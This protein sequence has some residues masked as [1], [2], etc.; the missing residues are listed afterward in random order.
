VIELVAR[1]PAERIVF[2][3]DTPYGRPVGGLFQAMR[4][5]RYAGLDEH[6]RAMLAGGTMMAMLEGR[7]LPPPKPPRV[8]Q[9]RLVHGRLA[10]VS[11]Y[12]Q[13]AFGSAMA[14]GPPPDRTKALPGIAMA[15]AVCRDPE[16]GAVGPAL[17]RIDALLAAGETLLSDGSGDLAMAFGLV[18][19]A[20][21]IAATEPVFSL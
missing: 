9:T 5:C 20:S 8:S 11:G 3:S 6:E 10:R 12:L 21:S 1:V 17:E 2:A 4:I 19:T 18:M 13:M 16:P 14:S 15:R 7:P